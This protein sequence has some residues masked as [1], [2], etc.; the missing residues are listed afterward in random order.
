MEL[1]SFEKLEEL[2]IFPLGTVLFPGAILP[3][4]IFEDR[5]K[6]MMRFA[7]DNGNLFGLSYRSD[8]LI[9][10]DTPP[11]VGSVGCL[12]K[13]QAVMPLEEGRMN[14]ISSGLVRYRIVELH[15]VTPF[16]IARVE[17]FTDDLEADQE[18]SDLFESMLDRC[19]RFLAAAQALD[20]ATTTIDE[21]LPE[22]PEA[23][24]LL[25]SSVLPIDNDAK[26]SLLEMTSTRSR[27]TRL[28]HHV[29]SALADY[30]QRI[31]IQ[32]RAKQNGHG[33][34]Q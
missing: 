8:A 22:D 16:I 17:A 6:Q 4:H 1:E 15:Q 23:F 20:E 13:I 34:L 2:A 26:Q 5:Y 7:T 11:E 25:I 14:V 10:R 27:L 29:I 19:K 33:K 21:D 31:E 12:A 3:L 28:R 32:A 24:S 18:L 9:G 30:T